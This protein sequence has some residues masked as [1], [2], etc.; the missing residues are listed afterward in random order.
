MTDRITAAATSPPV[1]IMSQRT[2]PADIATTVTTV[3]SL[4]KLN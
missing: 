4:N 3:S 2:A 1:K